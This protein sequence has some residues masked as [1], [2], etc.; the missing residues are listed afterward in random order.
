M[1]HA[2]IANLRKKMIAAEMRNELME[3][4]QEEEIEEEDILKESTITNWIN[5]FSRDWKYAMALKVIETAENN[6]NIKFLKAS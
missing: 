5:S 3:R 2:R 1:F 4:M 6:L